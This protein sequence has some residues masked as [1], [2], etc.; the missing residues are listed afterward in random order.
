MKQ[1]IPLAIIG[2]LLVVYS[3]LYAH[4]NAVSA[5][6]SGASVT[7]LQPSGSVE[8]VSIADTNLALA[9]RGAK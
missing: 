4:S 3:I 2:A 6:N 5:A 9:T 8:T 7:N 1:A